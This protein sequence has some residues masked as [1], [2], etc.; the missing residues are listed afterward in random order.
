MNTESKDTFYL[1]LTMAGA[2]SAGAY[3][4]GVMDY[5]FELLDKWESAKKGELEGVDPDLVPKHNVIISAMGGTSAGGMTT[6]MSAL[7]AIHNE[8]KPVTD[9]EV[10]NIGGPKDNIFYDSWINL[11]DNKKDTTL[12]QVLNTKDLKDGKITSLLN[13]A[14]I[15]KIAESAFSLP[16]AADTNPSAKLPSYFSPDFQLIIAHT[17]L[18]GIPLQVS[19]PNST[20][21]SDN[22]PG[23]VSYEHFLF[24]HFK[25]NGLGEIDPDKYLPLNPYEFKAKQR[26][27]KAAV[28]TGAFPIGLNFRTF[29]ESDFKPEYLK[30]V[31]SRLVEGKVGKEDPTHREDIDWS[32]PALNE[33][34][35]NFKAAT[36]DGGAINNEPYGQVLSILNEQHGSHQHKDSTFDKYGIVMID[37]FPDFPKDPTDEKNKYKVPEDL[38]GAIQPIIQTLWDQSKVKRKEFVEQF[39]DNRIYHG[40]IYPSKR[41][42]DGALLD[43]PIASASLGAFGGFLDIRFRHHD[44]YLGRNN[45]RNFLRAFLTKPY[46]GQNDKRNHP[47]HENWTLEMVNRFKVK[48]KGQEYLPIIPDMNLILEDKYPTYEEANKYSIPEMPKVTKEAIEKLSPLI[49][50]RAYEMLTIVEGKVVKKPAIKTK[51]W[52][53]WKRT[54]AWGFGLIIKK[55]KGI[56]SDQATEKL[57]EIIIEDLEKKGLLV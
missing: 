57:T 36:V 11:A 31:L 53:L 48:L 28:A 38:F 19:F 16:G 52:K 20:K 12:N 22:S 13:S 41:G 44:F 24:S 55:G 42:P 17:M 25:L 51:W 34:I 15:D 27:A 39:G 45:A 6:V 23:H 29:N 56:L 26:L 49:H 30:T 47:I 32:E 50:K 5:I 18:R 2:V 40:Y 14:F 46:Y 43:T 3:T 37:P 10:G 54:K 8:I 7:N 4:G 1:G 33:V 35:T 21:T 9:A